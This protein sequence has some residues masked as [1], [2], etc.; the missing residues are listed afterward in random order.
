MSFGFFIW[1]IY[2]SVVL[3]AVALVLILD[4]TFEPTLTLINDPSLMAF[5]YPWT[6]GPKAIISSHSGSF[7]G[8][9]TQKK[10]RYPTIKTGYRDLNQRID[11]EIPLNK[12]PF[13]QPWTFGPTLILNTTSASKFICSPSS[14][15]MD[16]K[17]TILSRLA[18][19]SSKR[20]FECK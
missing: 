3:A 13:H 14:P 9:I 18:F 15:H 10:S 5:F 20:S 2:D 8:T 7:S 4:I 6:A 19:N 11:P 16:V 17:T 1:A 12:G